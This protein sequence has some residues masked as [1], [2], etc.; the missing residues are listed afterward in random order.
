MGAVAGVAG[1]TGSKQDRQYS[2]R[3]FVLIISVAFL[4]LAVALSGM[5]MT[6]VRTSSRSIKALDATFEQVS[7]HQDEYRVANGRYAT[8][9]E[10]AAQGEQLEPELMVIRSAATASH[11]YLRI[12]DSSS[13]IVC[14]KLHELYG[15]GGSGDRP[16]CREAEGD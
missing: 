8:W 6:T 12:F 10:L 9:P 14:D 15:G 5:R 1:G 16:A 4:G 13:G 11:W 2:E 3:R 7:G